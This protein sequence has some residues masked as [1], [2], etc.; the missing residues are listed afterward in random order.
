MQ[1]IPEIGVCGALRAP[2]TPISGLSLRKCITPTLILL[3]L[4]NSF[5]DLLGITLDQTINEHRL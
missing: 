3:I 1:D 2:H 4:P 5:L